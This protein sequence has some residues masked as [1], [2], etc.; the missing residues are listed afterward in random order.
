MGLCVIVTFMLAVYTYSSFRFRLK[1]PAFLSSP[2]VRGSCPP[3]AWNDGTWEYSKPHTNLTS[4]TRKEDV[5]EFVP[6]EGCA[7]DRE[8]WWHLASEEETQWNR[9]PSVASYLWQPSDECDA[10]PLDGAAMVKDMVE[11]GGWLLLG[12]KPKLSQLRSRLSNIHID[13]RLHNGRPLLLLILRSLSPCPSDTKLYRKPILRAELGA[14]PVSQPLIA[15]CIPSDLPRR[16][17]DC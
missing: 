17:F 5:M 10:R 6:F 15:Y 12:G 2:R 4:L 3:Q 14:E 11:Q 8:Y 13:H 16:L 9:W 7:S 1:L